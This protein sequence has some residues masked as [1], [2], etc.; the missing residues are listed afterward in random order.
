M[1]EILFGDYGFNFEKTVE[2]LF[3]S[4]LAPGPAYEVITTNSTKG[5]I[6]SVIFAIFQVRLAWCHKQNYVFYEWEFVTTSQVIAVVVFLNLLI[7]L[8]NS[9]VQKVHEQKELYWKFTR[10][11][12]WVEFFDDTAVLPPPFTMLNA[13]W[14]LPLAIYR[15][16]IKFAPFE[17]SPCAP[18]S[19]RKVYLHMY[20]I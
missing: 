17:K 9:T 4:I 11:S 1:A 12:I 19:E 18:M 13:F 2:V 14:S 20:H 7:A 16:G 8:M 6:G 10:T 3:W 5:K 15:D